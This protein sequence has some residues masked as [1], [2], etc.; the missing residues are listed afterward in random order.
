M[1]VLFSCLICGY[2]EVYD[3]EEDTQYIECSFC[4]NGR[5]NKVGVCDELSYMVKNED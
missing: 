2:E 5:M 4:I 1:D 3:V